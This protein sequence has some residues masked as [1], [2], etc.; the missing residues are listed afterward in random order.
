[1][2]EL[3]AS[4]RKPGHPR[5]DCERVFPVDAP[6]KLQGLRAA[7]GFY[8][9]RSAATLPLCSIAER[10]LASVCLGHCVALPIVH[11]S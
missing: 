4:H 9:R 5:R 6:R 11:V 10:Q 7:P 2:Q 3:L 1:M 8:A